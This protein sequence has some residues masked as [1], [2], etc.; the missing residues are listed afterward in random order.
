MGTLGKIGTT[1]LLNAPTNA[2]LASS[3]YGGALQE[4]YLNGATEEE[5]TKYAIGS[6]AVEI[7]SEWITGGIPGTGGKG[8]TVIMVE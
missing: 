4:A 6:T 5:A 3:S 8:G 1:A 2:M 7:A